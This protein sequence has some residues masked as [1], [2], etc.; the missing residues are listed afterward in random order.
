MNVASMV[1]E[2]LEWLPTADAAD[3]LGVSVENV[4]KAV[5]RGRLRPGRKMGNYNLFSRE[6][7]ERYRRDSLGRRGRRK[8]SA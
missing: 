1:I 3:A 6:E 2:E 7:V 5:Q 8:E 4:N